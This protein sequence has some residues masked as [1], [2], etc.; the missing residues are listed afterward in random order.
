MPLDEWL[1]EAGASSAD[2]WDEDLPVAERTLWA[3]RVFP[4][5]REPG[6]YTRWLWMHR[7]GGASPEEKAAWARADRYSAAGIALLASQD[8]YFERRT[9]IRRK[10]S[11]T[12]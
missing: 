8:D 10:E 11:C 5:A 7:P 2:I 9:A 3:A 12:S 6:E 4:A 1:A